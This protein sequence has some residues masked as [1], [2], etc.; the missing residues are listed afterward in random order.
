MENSGSQEVMCQSE[1]ADEVKLQKTLL[2]NKFLPYYSSLRPE[3]DQLLLDIKVNLSHA[4]QRHEI[5][6]GALY[7][8]NRLQ[9]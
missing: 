9:R 5:W 1:G 6:P 4:V 7:W 3:A 2:Y 8:T